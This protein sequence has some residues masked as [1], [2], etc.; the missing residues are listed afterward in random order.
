MSCP[1]NIVNEIE[2]EIIDGEKESCDD[3]VASNGRHYRW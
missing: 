2:A 3:Y 1:A